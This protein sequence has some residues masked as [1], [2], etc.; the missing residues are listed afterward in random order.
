MQVSSDEPIFKSIFGDNWENLPY[1]MHRHYSI[2]PF[3]NDKTEV[4]G[5][6]D[7]FCKWYLKPFLM[8]SR[9]APSKNG[10]N[11]PVTVYFSNQED[12]PAFYFQRIFRYHERKPFIFNSR[13]LQIQDNEVMEIMRSRICW[14]ALYTWNGTKVIL[15]HKRYS[16]LFC[17]FNVPLPLT[18]LIG[19]SDAEEWAID[20]NSF[21]MRA[22]INHPILGKLYEYKGQF[23]FLD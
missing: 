13:M 1:V 21:A 2:R 7:V 18:W 9:T 4:C 8:L 3:S 12:S 22:T 6:L 23:S 15:K 20:N 17:G 10:K 14:H 19:R 11:I 16:F 5:T